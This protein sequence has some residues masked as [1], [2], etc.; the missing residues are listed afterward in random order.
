MR[1][2][3]LLAAIALGPSIAS[4]QDDLLVVIDHC[5]EVGLDEGELA[6]A[7]TLE[8]AASPRS[9]RLAI[10]IECAPTSARI[11]VE[12]ASAEVRIERRVGLAET[13]EHLRSRVVALVAAEL[14]EAAILAGGAAG[15]VAPRGEPS[16]SEPAEAEPAAVAPSLDTAPVSGTTP[17]APPATD[18]G[19]RVELY[20]LAGA[21]TLIWESALALASVE[22]GLAWD[23]LGV[24]VRVEGAPLGL[25]AADLDVVAATA[26]AGASLT[27]REGRFVGALGLWLEGGAVITSARSNT[28]GYVGTTE[29]SPALGA[30]V[31]LGG[32]LRVDPAVAFQ[33]A[34]D[35]GV[36]YG[37]RVEALDD[38]VHVYGA[39]VRV[40]LGVAFAP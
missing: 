4:A 39:S 11:V 3:A 27:L 17:A 33:A 35:A 15:R 28:A 21:R 37:V 25:A 30:H 36:F 10:A 16:A 7:V 9:V 18:D 14:V 5:D 19:A 23:W 32:S 8:T 29:V 6:R 13:P 12:D 24:A 40:G 34:I 26:S 2:L 31:R 38:V 22:L 1:S 20:A